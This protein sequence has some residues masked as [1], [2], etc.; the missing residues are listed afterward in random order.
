MPDIQISDPYTNKPT[1]YKYD[2]EDRQLL[3]NLLH[4]YSEKLMQI[5]QELEL[6]KQQRGKQAQIYRLIG[7][8]LDLSLYA[9]GVLLGLIFFILL[10][11]WL[12]FRYNM[13]VSNQFKGFESTDLFVIVLLLVLMIFSLTMF[14]SSKIE[15]NKNSRMPTEK[16]VRMINLLEEDTRTIADKLEKVMRV[17]IEVQ[18]QIEINLARKLELD[19]RIGDAQSALEYYYSVIGAR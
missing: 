7:K 3:V 16:I 17:T 15:A 9:S 14:Q 4:E 5:S 19:L 12:T 18:D 6:K 10:F 8:I 2:S 13:F 1:F 11:S